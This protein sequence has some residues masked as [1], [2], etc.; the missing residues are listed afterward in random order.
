MTDPYYHTLYCVKQK[1]QGMENPLVP[2]LIQ[3]HI[4]T[5]SAPY[6]APEGVLFY[7]SMVAVPGVTHTLDYDNPEIGGCCVGCALLLNYTLDISSDQITLTIHS[8][9][10]MAD[11]TVPVTLGEPVD[12]Y[13]NAVVTDWTDKVEHIIK[14]TKLTIPC[15]PDVPHC[16]YCY[17]K[18][19]SLP[20]NLI[21]LNRKY[22]CIG[23]ELRALGIK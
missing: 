6:P 14:L 23:C 18:L 20:V 4:I 15:V 17:Q 13:H 5:K 2:I 7:E 21:Y 12:F 8:E 10:D 19:P 1:Q 11:T 22:C 3:K 16:L 9:G